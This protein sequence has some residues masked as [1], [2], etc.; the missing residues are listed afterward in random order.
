MDFKFGDK[1]EALREEIREFAKK[2]LPPG[3]LAVML[4]EESR[5]EDWAVVMSMS[6]KLSE[7]G[8]LTMSWPEEYGGKGASRLEQ[9]VYLEESGYWGIPGTT[10]GI[11][12]VAW[13]GPSLMMYGSQEQ[14]TTR[15]S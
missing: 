12:G 2:E 8:W 5:D 14:S 7:R 10:M 6:K 13:V 1:E 4:E 9:L 3:W 11:S 15:N